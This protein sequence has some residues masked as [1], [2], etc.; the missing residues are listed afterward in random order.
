MKKRLFFL[1]FILLITASGFSQTGIELKG[2]AGI[3]YTIADI[4]EASGEEGVTLEDWGEF[5]WGLR[6]QGLYKFAGNMQ[7]G[8]EI[9]YNYLFWYSYIAP[10]PPYTLYREFGVAPVNISAVFEYDLSEVMSVQGGAGV[11]IYGDGAALGLFSSFYYKWQITDSIYIPAFF[12]LDAIFATGFT[13]PVSVG[14][15]IIYKL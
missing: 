5:Y 10:Y 3:G 1:C 2:L 14:S 12:R 15:G 9:G 8:A 11:Y 13:V 6:V 4:E 7:A